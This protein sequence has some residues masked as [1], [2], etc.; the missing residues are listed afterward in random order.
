MFGMD[1]LIREFKEQLNRIE[2]RI[3]NIEMARHNGKLASTSR[4]LFPTL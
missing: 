4:R 2:N 3:V 1:V